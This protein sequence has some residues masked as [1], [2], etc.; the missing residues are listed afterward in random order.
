MQLII[1][2]NT[3]YVK[4]YSIIGTINPLEN[5]ISIEIDGIPENFEEKFFNFTYENDTLTYK[6]LPEVP[7]FMIQP[8]FNYSFFLW[9]DIASDEQKLIEYRT[10]ILGLFKEIEICKNL[11]IDCSDL[12]K[13]MNLIQT[14]Y[15]YITRRTF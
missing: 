12:E 14:N 7:D 13:K 1:D 5:E 6:P 4:S 11:G 8:K 9:E 3:K 2:N 10:K 15:N